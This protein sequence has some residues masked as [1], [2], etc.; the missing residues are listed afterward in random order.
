MTDTLARLAAALADRY[1]IERELGQGGMA[2]VYLAE[3]LKHQ[4]RVAIK[5]MRPELA[6]AI[7]AD[8]FLREITTTANLRHPHIVPLYDS[9]ESA[10]FVYYVMPFV[11]GESLRARLNREK[12][13]PVDDALQIAREVADALSYA[14]GRGV[15]HRDI[16][17]ENIL[18]ESGHA[19]VADFGIARAVSAAAGATL[20]ETG[21]ALGTPTYMSPEQA[22]GQEVDGRTDGYA[23]ACVL[24][25]MLVGEP[26]YTGPTPQAIIARRLS[27]PVPSLRVVREA[28]PVSVEQAIT[29]ALARVPADRFATASQFAAALAGNDGSRTAA[30]AAGGRGIRRRGV[31]AA[32]GGIALLVLVLAVRALLRHEQSVTVDRGV[33]AVAPF[34]VTAA[35]SSLGYLRRGMVDLLTAKLSGTAALRPVDT[36]TLLSAWDRA[37][38]NRGDLPESRALAVAAR[39]G[40]G[41]LVQ[42]EIVGSAG[43]LSLSA[44][45]LLVPDGR[46]ETR[47]T[48]EGLPDSLTQLVDQLAGQLLAL[49]AGEGGQRVASLTTSLPALRAYLDG[50]ALFRSGVY[51]DA[52]KKFEAAFSADSG[53]ALAALG[54]AR[55][56]LEGN[57]DPNAPGVQAA[58]RLRDRLSP[59][60]RALLA[61]MLGPRYPAPSGPLDGIRAADRL[62]QIAPDSPDAWYLLGGFLYTTGPLIGIADAHARAAAA[63]ARA[64]SLDSSYAP[65]NMA[66]LAAS[67]HDTAAL[68]ALRPRLG[69]DSTSAH[70]VDIRW[71]VATALGDTAAAR[72]AFQSDSMAVIRSDGWLNT[73]L[74]TLVITA[75]TEGLDLRDAAALLERTRL[76]A[77][78]GAQRLSLLLLDRDVNLMRGRPS[79]AP[80]LP[81]GWDATY[82]NARIVLEALFA[83]GD[84]AAAVIAGAALMRDIGRPPPFWLISR[85]AAGQYAFDRNR[86]PVAR[87]AAADLRKIRGSGPDSESTAA[88]AGAYALTLEAQIAVRE[89]A[90]GAP[91]L[92]RQLDS[93]LIY[94]LG[95]WRVEYGNLVAARMH[96]ERGEL[97]AALAAVRRRE[98]QGGGHPHPEYV[99]FYREEGRLAALTGDTAGAVRAYRRYLALRSDPDPALRPQADSVRAALALIDRP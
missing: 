11:E 22:L 82:R 98:W 31:V 6:A 35:D 23:L 46:V 8:R 80:P 86:L 61:V 45:V 69:G 15:I 73:G 67:L 1:R 65:V 30:P 40:A 33:L 64:L 7:G 43:R 25:E 36:R 16:K 75:Q 91:E 56:S 44:V 94:T 3:D 27:E 85:Y 21:L 39:L 78:T 57:F 96:E 5:V 66:G 84:S 71:R 28:V 14:H 70:G 20:T 19:M 24:Y 48:A 77:A 62:T 29:K 72:R 87:R 99:T 89:R 37:T 60:D 42:G 41:R 58:W 26:P 2:T 54:I 59:R 4:R 63:L 52:L 13:L 9:G 50:Q 81:V 93:A 55:A 49:G 18:L 97:P 74:W 95:D 10:G 79:H 47:A 17:P 34:R 76:A 88:E 90:P 83:D 51:D 12:Q 92:V 38:G 53:F 32:A 68:R